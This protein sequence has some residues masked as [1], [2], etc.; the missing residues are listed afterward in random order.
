MRKTKA[1]A[2]QTRSNLLHAA[3]DLFHERGVSRTSLNDIARR[4]NVT[5]GAFYWHFKNKEDLFEALFQMIFPELGTD[6]AACAEDGRP[7]LQIHLLQLFEQ[8]QHNPV[9]QKFFAILELKCEHTEE[10]RAI[11]EV[12]N[13]YFALWEAE[14]HSILRQ[15][16]ARQQLPADLDTATAAAFLHSHI[17]GLVKHWLRHPERIDLP[18]SAP[19]IVEAALFALQHSPALRLSA[20]P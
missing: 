7:L 18:R 2:Q 19:K 14:L 5:R 3:L 13:K 10:N 6:F 4:A 1:E 12:G 20:E 9:H 16:I 8:L 15:S 11:I 17:G